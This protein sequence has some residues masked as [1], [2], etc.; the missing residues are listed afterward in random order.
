MPI[1]DG[2][3]RVKKAWSVF[4]GNDRTTESDVQTDYSSVGASSSYPHTY[5]PSFYGKD[6][7]LVSAIQNRIAIDAAQVKM[8]QC[9]VD[10]NERYV[11]TV[12]SGLNN[13]LSWNANIDQSGFEFKMHVFNSLLCDGVIAVVPYRVEPN[14]NAD[15][16]D[17]REMRVGVIT[18]WYP[19][20]VKVSLY[21]DDTGRREEVILPKSKVAIVRNPFYSVMNERNSLVQMLSTKY[22]I[23]DMIDQ[24]LGSSKLD[25]I[26]QL[27]YP[28]KGATRQEQA[29][30]R[31]ED[32]D[33]QLSES[34]Y[35]IGYIDG[36]EKIIQLNR[37]IENNLLDQIEYMEKSLYTQLSITP[38]ILNGTANSD[39]MTNYYNRTVEPCITVLVDEMTRK[40]V[41]GVDPKT[42][43][44][45]NEDEQILFF[46]DPFKLVPVEKLPELADKLLRNEMATSNEMRA[47]IGWKPAKDPK[48]DELRNANLNH[49]DEAQPVPLTEDRDTTQMEGNQN[50]RV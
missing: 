12:S 7:S 20:K 28:F 47:S 10:E 34:K 36:S 4:R 5:I 33:K 37:P 39:V 35:G 30:K 32:L 42:G 22:K 21:N 3:A 2:W 1:R 24:R 49:P 14:L 23:L 44:P 16:F 19:K 11:E 18:Q 31:R 40:F 9:K 13:V 15:E 26:I 8:I 6:K 17:I 50:G 41:R 45:L 48:A 46:R 29:R 25:L 38:E 27:P 43:L